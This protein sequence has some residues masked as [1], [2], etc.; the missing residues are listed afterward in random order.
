MFILGWRNIVLIESNWTR[1]I[2]FKTYVFMKQTL[3][4]LYKAIHFNGK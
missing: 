2:L 1:K 4:N 3:L